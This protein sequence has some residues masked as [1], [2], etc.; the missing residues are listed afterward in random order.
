[1]S[2]VQAHEQQ[3]LIGGEWVGADAGSTFE[4]DDP[5]TGEPTTIAA[6]A[7]VADAKRA[8]DAAASAFPEWSATPPARRGELLSA[9]AELLMQ[10]A[11]EI[12][13]TMTEECGAV[14]GWGMFNCDLASAMLR[15]AAAQVA[16]YATTRTYL[17]V[18]E[19]HGFADLQEPIRRAF[20]QN[21]HAEM[22]RLAL[23]MAEVLAV[24]GTP[25]SRRFTH[26]LVA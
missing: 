22:I 17:P 26:L 1:M 11:P 12:A 9:A 14:F 19:A 16:F 13:Q 3:L 5:F 25:E 24:A 23:P 18:L 15:E 7:G 10:R 20:V 8:V 4:K 6:A 21:D 2:T